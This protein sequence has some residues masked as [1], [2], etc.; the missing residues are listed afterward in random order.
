[1]QHERECGFVFFQ[2]QSEHELMQSIHFLKQTV[3]VAERRSVEEVLVFGMFLSNYVCRDVAQHG[4]KNTIETRNQY[5][6]YAC[7]SNKR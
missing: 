2:S 4:L 3:I 1:L 6:A 5:L 7:I